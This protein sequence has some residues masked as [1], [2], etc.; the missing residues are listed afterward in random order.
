MNP[1]IP[2]SAKKVLWVLI[3]VVLL[4]AVLGLATVLYRTLPGAAD[5]P[6]FSDNP[7]LGV[8]NLFN[9]RTEDSIGTWYSSFLLLFC[10]ALSAVISVAAKKEGRR[11]VGHWRVLSVVFLYLSIDE[12][13]TIH[14]KM[15]PIARPVLQSL[16]IQL[17][18]FTSRA[19]VIPASILLLVFL[20]AYFRFFLDLPAKQR[21]LFL[22][23]GALYVG[24]AIGL[25]MLHG[26]ITTLPED[27]SQLA[28]IIVPVGEET[29]EMLGIAVFTYALL[30]YLDS[31]LQEVRFS[32]ERQN[33]DEHDGN[34]V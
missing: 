34:R 30:S 1:T 12:S 20:L 13:S 28:R 33:T 6:L 11:Y 32:F 29:F 25:E 26:F 14:E 24:G 22:I 27:S 5:S 8:L 17:G 18:G 31:R 10:S 2:V 19:W 7:N 15:G 9:L 21:L 4:L 16:G 3:S 23:S